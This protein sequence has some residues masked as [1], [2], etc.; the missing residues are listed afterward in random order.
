[1]NAKKA[2]KIRRAARA[3]N[4]TPEQTRKLEREAKTSTA[5]RQNDIIK[6]CDKKIAERA[7]KDSALVLPPRLAQPLIVSPET[8]LR[9]LEA[10]ERQARAAVGSRVPLIIAGK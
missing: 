10:N 4:M 5:E 9:Q 3:F 7:I 1:M 2:K 6:F 8:A